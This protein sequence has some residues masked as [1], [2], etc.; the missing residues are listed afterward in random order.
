MTGV[1]TCAL[2]ILIENQLSDVRMRLKQVSQQ[3]ETLKNQTS[4]AT[5][6]IEMD[7]VLEF[8][9]NGHI[10]RVSHFSD[11]LS[12]AF[13]EAFDNL[14]GLSEYIL[15]FIIRYTPSIAFIWL[16]VYLFKKLFAKLHIQCPIKKRKQK[17][18]ALKET[19][20]EE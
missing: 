9:A 20:K 2:P 8:S 11:R 19:K 15:F 16:L 12:N 14:K 5:Y 13:K 10:V 17:Q 6:E 7:E 4:Y 1:Q 3:F 18:Q